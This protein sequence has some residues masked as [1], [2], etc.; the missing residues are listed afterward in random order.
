MSFSRNPLS[1]SVPDPAFET[2]LRDRGYLEILDV[3]SSSSPTPTPTTITSSPTRPITAFY[4]RAL[5]STRTLLSLLSL[6]P[7]A[8]LTS[9]DLSKDTPSWTALFLARPDSYA[10]PPGPTQARMRVQENVRR[11]A[12]NYASL[13]FVFLAC[14]L[15]RMPVALLGL[16]ASLALWEGLRYCKDA[17][18]WEVR[19]PSVSNF[20]VRLTLF[21][22]AFILYWSNVQIALFCAICV[23]YAVMI[24]HALL[25][26]LSPPNQ[27][28]AKDESKR[29]QQQKKRR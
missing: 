4:A 26:K 1:L 8:K 2:W 12:R 15:Y 14:S 22:T 11:Y 24:L 7:F 10:Y 16:V 25:R 20:L 17:Y 23:S 28:V 9:E 13:F 3:S 5:C 27:V 6:N 29:S 18:E 19:Y 21:A